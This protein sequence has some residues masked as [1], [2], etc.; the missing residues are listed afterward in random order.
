MHFSLLVASVGLLFL[1]FYKAN[2]KAN[3]FWSGLPI[4]SSEC[5]CCDFSPGVGFYSKGN[6][7]REKLW[8]H[9]SAHT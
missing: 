6:G 2:F 4:S 1:T 3:M 5:H 9:T 8:Y 7:F